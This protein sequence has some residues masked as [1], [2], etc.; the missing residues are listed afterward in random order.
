MKKRR[1]IHI[2]D[3]SKILIFEDGES[4]IL[5]KNPVVKGKKIQS[6]F[7]IKKNV[8]LG[9]DF[10]GKWIL[11]DYKRNEILNEFPSNEY[12]RL[13]SNDRLAHSKCEHYY[14][15]QWSNL[16]DFS[17][18]KIL[19]RK[20]YIIGEFSCNYAFVVKEQESNRSNFI[21]NFIDKNGNDLLKEDFYW[22]SE[23]FFPRFRNGYAIINF[24]KG[25]NL[26]G[27]DGNI[28]YETSYKEIQEVLRGFY[29]IRNDSN[30]SNV[31]HCNDPKKFISREWLVICRINEYG[32][33]PVLRKLS[34]GYKGD[35]MN[36]LGE[37]VLNE[38]IKVVPPIL[39]SPGFARLPSGKIFYKDGN[40]YNSL[41]DAKREEK[42][43]KETIKSLK[44]LLFENED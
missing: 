8:Y 30:L 23:V 29:I 10:D 16:I 6:V 11:V 3:D 38:D 44:N 19:D 43:R 12:V 40:V 21:C 13:I 27:T 2:G 17:G 18:R 4:V 42:S 26:V 37:F 20:F 24:G 35:Y 39:E 32:Y 25:M 15:W 28:V 33:F 7:G 22:T 41:D 34:N 36:E 9:R 1:I 31:V 5:G 14:R